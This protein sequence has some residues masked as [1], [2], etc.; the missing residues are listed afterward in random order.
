MAAGGHFEQKNKSCV[1]IWN[2]EKCKQQR[3]SDIQ[4]GHRRPFWEKNESIISL[5]YSKAW[6]ILY[7]TVSCLYLLWILQTWTDSLEIW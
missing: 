6:D 3:I 2:G 7:T 1:L 5:Q 4:N